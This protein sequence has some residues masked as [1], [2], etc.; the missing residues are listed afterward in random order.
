MMNF[1]IRKYSYETFYKPILFSTFAAVSSA[2]AA[3]PL[4]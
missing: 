2:Q 4:I 3:P 1:D